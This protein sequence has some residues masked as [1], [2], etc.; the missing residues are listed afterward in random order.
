MFDENSAWV[1]RQGGQGTQQRQE[2]EKEEEKQDSQGKET[3]CKRSSPARSVQSVGRKQAW[4]KVM[5]VAS[6]AEKCSVVWR[7]DGTQT[8]SC[9]HRGTTTNTSIEKQDTVQN[10]GGQRD[11]PEDEALLVDLL[12]QHPKRVSC[13]ESKLQPPHG[14][15]RTDDRN[16]DRWGCSLLDPYPAVA[17]WAHMVRSILP[18]AILLATELKGRSLSNAP[19]KPTPSKLLTNR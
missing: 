10:R 12:V 19:R 2:E 3:D 8:S 5:P 9:K 16:G 4:G 14:S 1:P 11:P 18:G 17:R 7:M 6:T 13:C 15:K